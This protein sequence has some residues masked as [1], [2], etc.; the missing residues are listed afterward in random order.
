MLPSIVIYFSNKHLNIT[1]IPL[2]PYGW[3]LLAVVEV[4]EMTKKEIKKYKQ[5]K[6]SAKEG[7]ISGT[8]KKEKKIVRLLDT[9]IDS[10]LSVERG[11]QKIKGIGPMFAHAVCVATGIDPKTRFESLN[12]ENLKKIENSIK[13]PSVP[14]WLLNRRKDIKTGKDVH[15]V[16][17]DVNLRVREDIALLKKIRS[18]RGI[19]HELGLPVRGQRTRSSFR[20]NKTVGV[21]KKKVM[22]AKKGG[23]K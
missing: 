10:A 1:A 4:N 17:S 15:I 19:R 2:R 12:E 8:P 23:K 13:N 6:G 9:D 3:S 7:K 11:I 18:Y 14:R 20:K 16:A 5:E 22:Q 21:V